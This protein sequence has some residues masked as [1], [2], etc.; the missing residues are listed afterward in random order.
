MMQLKGEL[1]INLLPERYIDAST[2][3]IL[4]Q[5]GVCVRV[6]THKKKDFN[7]LHA[8][9]TLT[10]HSVSMLDRNHVYLTW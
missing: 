5:G 1:F 2:L 10:A 6:F 4:S 9:T 3:Y 7:L 8:V